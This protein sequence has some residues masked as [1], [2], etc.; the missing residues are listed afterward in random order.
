V[1]LTDAQGHFSHGQLDGSTIATTRGLPG[2]STA[3]SNARSTEL[4]S[5]DTQAGS[6]GSGSAPLAF[7]Y[8][9]D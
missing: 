2:G 3:T 5:E 4:R 6:V 9:L 8:Y 7:L 1:L